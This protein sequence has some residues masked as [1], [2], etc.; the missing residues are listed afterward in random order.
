MGWRHAALSIY[1]IYAL[2]H[3]V[4]TRTANIWYMCATDHPLTYM[5]LKLLQNQGG[6]SCASGAWRKVW[7][8]TKIL[9]PNI[10]YFV[11]ILRFVTIYPLFKGSFR[12]DSDKRQL[13]FVSSGLRQRQ[14]SFSPDSDERQLPFVQTQMKDSFLLS[15]L[16]WKTASLRPDWDKRRLPFA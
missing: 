10:R 3:S 4:V 9:S 12:P 2:D 1:Y 6:R 14:L 13:S 11:A 8:R 15:R 5:I 7:T 16:R